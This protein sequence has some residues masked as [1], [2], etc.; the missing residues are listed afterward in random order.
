M[1]TSATACGLTV[2]EK[3]PHLGEATSF[4]WNL[5][6]LESKVTAGLGPSALRKDEIS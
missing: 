1:V 6:F 5:F 4:L 2:M 3:Y